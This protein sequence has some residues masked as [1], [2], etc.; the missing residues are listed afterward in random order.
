MDRYVDA[1]RLLGGPDPMVRRIETILSVGTLGLWDLIDAK[2]ELIRMSNELLG[3]WREW[4]SGDDWRSRTERIE[5]AH[6]I[7]VISSFLE[8]LD[9]PFTLAGRWVN[10]PECPS[11]RQPYEMTVVRI[12]AYYLELCSGLRVYVTDLA[13]W[14]RLPEH[15]RDRLYAYLGTPLAEAAVRRYEDGYRR[16]AM[17][18]PEFAFWAG[19]V[20]HQATRHGLAELERLLT[21]IASGA[22]LPAEVD[23]VARLQQAVL[24][25]AIV[26]TGDV[27]DGV[28]LPSLESAYI[29]P[30]YRANKA[31]RGDNPSAESWW[32][33]L[34]VRDD[35]PAFVASYL[36][37]SAA[38][39]A[40][41]LVLGQPG[42]GKS[43]LTK[44]LAARLPA[45]RFLPVRVP[46]REVAAGADIQEQ[47]EQ[48]LY[49][50]T[51]DR[52]TWPALAM[53][54]GGALPVVMLDG[55]DELLQAT[56]VQQSDYLAKVARFQQR[57][58]D[59]GRA[60]AFLV[61]S[62]TAV[63]DRAALP[64]GSVV[65]RLEPFSYEQIGS[66]LEV[67]N[68]ENVKPFTFWDAMS[69]RT[70]A[71]QPLLLLML[72]LWNADGGT[73][74]GA[75]GQAELYERLMR[76]FAER[77]LA[78]SH[79]PDQVPRL[80][81]QELL[82]L[83]L[84]SF[85]MFNRG[86]QWATAAE[87]DAD[88]AGL[89]IAALQPGPAGFATP[90]SAGEKAFGRF[91]FVHRSQAT[92]DRDV[93][94]TYEFLHATFGEFL[95][96]RLVAR[97]LGELV[98]QESSLGGVNDGL[99]SALLSWSTMSSRFPILTFLKDLM[100]ARCKDMVLRLFH[101][102]ERRDLRAFP[103]Y[104]PWI[105]GPPRRFAYYSANLMLVALC[106]GDELLLSELLPGREDLQ[107]EWQR[108]ALLWR[109]LT[110]PDEW[111]GLVGLVAVR[112]TAT[113]DPYLV[114]DAGWRPAP[115]DPAWVEEITQPTDVFDL[116]RRVSFVCGV[117]ER[118]LLHA[119]EPLLGIPY[120]GAAEAVTKARHFIDV[121]YLGQDDMEL[122]RHVLQ[123]ALERG[124][125]ALAE[126]K[127]II[128]DLALLPKDKAAEIIRSI[129]HA[130]LQEVARI[131]GIEL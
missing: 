22:A 39:R 43:V 113:P 62:R 121:L 106:S 14:E 41:L 56:G 17:D 34:P 95:I 74:S 15:E 94:Q 63:A 48:A 1:V 117:E 67:W 123:R 108:H 21:T 98:A 105:S 119:V 69:Q 112:P 12:E 83:S 79:P 100:P 131:L 92:R 35:L 61:T 54:A 45:G 68:A 99:L 18:V 110:G 46:L 7:L 115:V 32:A 24:G 111:R 5:A 16:L 60:V 103:G 78:K 51:G 47:I 116:H 50:L 44:V 33:E 55:F 6:T 26:E 37:G 9:L 70:L 3:R 10:P 89:Q 65:A 30:R 8:V 87:V 96:A 86:R 58:L 42:A 88:L 82:H 31:D 13:A 49:L 11:P 130:K 75:L 66:W 40:P 72:A 80:V 128:G 57:E 93:L 64:D 27:P 129:P 125:H 28:R 104:E 126:E 29:T 81:E 101:D 73:F 77:E 124:T 2:S 53:A 109:A 36:T 23:R 120:T 25:R 52:V 76:R 84:V 107:V 114:L 71:E 59:L 91:F 118:L 19:M 127:A 38:S 90:L 85:S 20:E 97:L 102:L 122:R 4:R